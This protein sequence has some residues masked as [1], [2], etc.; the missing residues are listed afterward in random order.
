MEC[1]ILLPYILN[2][3]KQETV[4]YNEYLVNFNIYMDLVYIKQF[5]NSFKSLNQY[6]LTSKL[7]L[8]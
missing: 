6:S 5:Q 4:N 7:G 1:C 3:S 8:V 2:S